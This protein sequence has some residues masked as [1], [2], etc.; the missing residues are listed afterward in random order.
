MNELERKPFVE[1]AE[2]DR[3][4]YLIE[5]ELIKLNKDVE[6]EDEIELKEEEEEEI[7]ETPFMRYAKQAIPMVSKTTN[8]FHF[9]RLISSIRSIR[10]QKSKNC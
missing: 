3:K 10:H 7:S 9:H 6:S 5:K 2:E 4:R 1:I 8:N